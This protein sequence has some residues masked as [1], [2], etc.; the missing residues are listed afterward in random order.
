MPVVVPH[1]DAGEKRRIRAV[2][3]LPID[4]LGSGDAVAPRSM[5]PVGRYEF[6][7][8]KLADLDR[9]PVARIPKAHDA[10]LTARE[11][12]ENSAESPKV[13]AAMRCSS[14]HSD[15]RRI[16]MILMG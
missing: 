2:P 12:R 14:T 5:G 3:G 11:Q 8:G 9:L 15:M 13:S 4:L 6:L 7:Q 1:L 16:S 10:V